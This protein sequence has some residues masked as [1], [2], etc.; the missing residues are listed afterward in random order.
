[1][2]LTDPPARW[3]VALQRTIAVICWVI[4]VVLVLL[5]IGRLAGWD[6]HSKWLIALSTAWPLVVL[7]GLLVVIGGAYLRRRLLGVA[8]VLM[9]LILAAAWAPAWIGSAG[10]GPKGGTAL[11]VLALNVEYSHDTG[12][13]ASRQIK[14]NDPDVVVLSELSP[15]TLQHLDLRQYRYSWLRPEANAFGQGVYSRWPL[16]QEST[17]S[18]DGLAML[19]LTVA[20]PAGPVRLYQ[21]HTN[22]PQGP[23]AR[24]TWSTQLTMLK[25]LMNSETLP[26]VAAGD[27][28]AS[29]WDAPFTGLLGGPRRILDAGAGRGYLAT[30]PSGRKWL[31]PVFALDH[32]LVS[33][34][35][36]V[37]GFRVLGPVGSDHRAIVADLNLGVATKK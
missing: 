22:A 5:E 12:A 8:A 13:A 36:G 33:H 31:P 32:V 4:A 18:V 2:T 14:A 28:N 26:V 3:R 6:T 19:R 37:R 27:F 10:A 9:V 25:Q 34:G 11:R 23:A 24:H 17:W 15:L 21:V 29:H 7:P 35:I 1:V 20:T 16:S 30:W